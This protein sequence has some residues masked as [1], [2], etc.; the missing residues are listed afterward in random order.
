MDNSKP[1]IHCVKQGLVL[2]KDSKSHD[3]FMWDIFVALASQ[4]SNNLSEETRKGLYEK[5]DQGW[6]PGN[7]KRGYKTVGDLGHKKW[8]MDKDRLDAKFIAKAF[9]LYDTGE[10]TLRTLSP[11]LYKEGWFSSVG[12]PISTSELH[13]LLIDCFYCGEFEWHD[14]KYQGK[15]EPLITKELFYRVQE[16]LN[17]KL[18]G[19]YKK[20]EFLFGHEL[21]VCGE[22]GRSVTAEVQKGHSYYHCTRHGNNCS[23]RKYIREEEIENQV[24]EIFGKLRIDNQRLIEWIRK[25]LEESHKSEDE[26]HVSTV[27]DLDK[28]YLILEKRLST[29][30]DDMADGRINKEFYE[31]KKQQYEDEVEAILDAKNKHAEA[32]FDYLQLGINIFELSQRGSEIY[33]AKARPKEKRDLL[34]FLFLNLKL[35]DGKVVPVFQNG[36]QV[37]ASRAET[38]DWLRS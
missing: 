9:E 30:Y 10:Y 1:K 15:H 12:K 37:V 19:K 25:A 17:R 2:D 13:K 20:H 26:Y 31:I 16:R 27:K 11:A 5:A 23:Q 36:F 6:Y 8:V 32:N 7:H 22:C 33:K 35:K 14:R 21:L 29:L 18:T 28:Q 38:K 4:Y 34:N 3:K 24:F